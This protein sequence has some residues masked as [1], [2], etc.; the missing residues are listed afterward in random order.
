MEEKERSF[1]QLMGL[2]SIDISDQPTDDVVSAVGGRG[3]KH[4]FHSNTCPRLY[5]IGTSS[6]RLFSFL[7]AANQSSGDPCSIIFPQKVAGHM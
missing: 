2:G 6:P 3:N 5:C 4:L 1:N 7:A